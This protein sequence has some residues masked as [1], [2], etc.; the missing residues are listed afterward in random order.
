[1]NDKFQADWVNATANMQSD[2]NNAVAN[3]QADWDCI[4][5]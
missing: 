2:W 4:S 5:L 3:M 1:M